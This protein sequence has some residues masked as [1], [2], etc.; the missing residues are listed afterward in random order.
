MASLLGVLRLSLLVLAG[1]LGFLAQA[2]PARALKAIEIGSDQGRV[3]ITTLGEL[4]ESRGDSLQVETAAGEDGLAGRM[5]VSATT[6][7]TNPNWIVFALT[8]PS[9]RPVERWLSAD[10]YSVI[11]SGVVWPDLDARRIEAVTPS[12]GFVPERIKNDRAD[13]FRIT[14]EPGQTITYVVELSSE[15]FTRLYLWKPLDYEI[16]ISDRQLFNGVMLGLTGLLAIFLTAIFAANHKLV[17]PAAALVAWCALAYLCV[18]FGFFHKLFLLKPEANAVYRAATESALAASLVVFLHVFLRLALWHGLVRMLITVWLVAQFSLIA[19]AII[20]PR[21]AATFARLSFVFIGLTGTGL[22][23][24]LALRGQDRA[25]SLIPTWI[26][27]LV[28]IFGAGVTLIGKLSGEVVVFG[29]VSGLVLILL[30]IGF[31]VTQYAFRSIEPLYGAAPSELQSRSIAVDASG[32]AVWEWNARRDEV[33]VSPSVELLLGLSPGDLSTRT[34]E[35]LRH[36]HPSDRERFRLALFTVQERR[37]GK[38]CC[39]FRLRQAD[40]N[41]RWFEIE[42]AGVPGSDPRS[43]KCVGLIRDVTDAKRAHERL[44][45]DAV[46]DSLTGLPNRELLLDRLQVSLTRAK[47]EPQIR[48]TMLIIDIDKF[49][50]L[51]SSLGLV[52]GD[53]LLLTIARRLQRHIGPADTLARIGGDRFALMMLQDQPVPELAQHA[54]RIRRSLRSPI[55]IAGQE[56]VLTGSIGIAVYDE[57]THEAA[58]LVK[59]AEIAMFRAKRAGADRIEVFSPEMKGDQDDRRA[60]ETELRRAMEKNQ[61]RVAYLPVIYLPTEELA[62]FEAVARWDHPQLGLVDP[63]AL[64]PIAE[65]TDLI[66]KLGAYL[67]QRT[68]RDVVAWQKEFPR[69]EAPLFVSVNIS[70]RHLFRQDIVQEIRHILGRTVVPKGSIRIEV[71]EQVAL[72]NPE[73]ATEILEWLRG[74]GAEIVI[75]EF[76]TGFTSLS[77]L[78]RLPFDTIKLDQ[79]FMQAGSVKGGNDSVLVRSMVALAHELGKNVVAKGVET[80]NEV[81]FLRSIECEYAQGPYC[82]NAIADTE[83]TQVLAQVRTSENKHK[84]VGMFRTKPKKKGRQHAGATD[85]PEV[86]VVNGNG[87]AHPPQVVN[88]NGAAHPTHANGA[89]RPAASANGAQVP[90]PAAAKQAESGVNGAQRRGRLSRLRQEQAAGKGSLK[91][92]AAQSAPPPPS[93]AAPPVSQKSAPPPPPPAALSAPS[94]LMTRLSEVLPDVATPT[95]RTAPPPAAPPP[96]TKNGPG[97]GAGGPPPLRPINV[98]PPPAAVASRPP[99]VPPSAPPPIQ[100]SAMGPPPMGA[101]PPPAPPPMPPKRSEAPPPPPPPPRPVLVQ[102]AP[103]PPASKGPPIPFPPPLSSGSAGVPLAAPPPPRPAAAPISAPAPAA[104]RPAAV[105]A[106]AANGGAGPGAAPRPADPDFSN[107]PPAIAES[108]ARLAGVSR[109]SN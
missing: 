31:T 38:I 67:L 85:K 20:D 80:A 53:S 33:K 9:D 73:Q 95:V 59:N 39:D 25:L 14:L 94:P 104:V 7:G 5:S 105:G 32:A 83:V 28:W 2:E 40:N 44:L 6:P 30:S 58:D 22:V 97:P 108:L 93:P 87:A 35:F 81:S 68:S 84:P 47:S 17:F 26:L 64:V 61:L 52:L 24:F 13:L 76:G 23:L 15:R 42:A 65:D 56:I 49:T 51:N 77:Y 21:L 74:A 19:V 107:L 27:F 96:R 109:K 60:L 78:E 98:G 37:D 3:E 46:H 45:H 91:D 11:G 8:N 36:L 34:D 82:G 99:P 12:I 106:G 90:Q 48:P 86:V 103:P 54:E 16:K 57:Q 41:Y 88:G 43:F 71:T 89:M 102:P 69:T 72:E 29:L 50:S 75:D 63:A 66:A 79:A 55:K 92:A 4:Y 70:C 100:P 1:F 18:D 10:R 62:G 101:A